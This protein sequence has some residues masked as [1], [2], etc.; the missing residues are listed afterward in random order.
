M[1]IR[2]EGKIYHQRYE[3]GQ[4][5]TELAMTGKTKRRG[6]KVTFKP[7]PEIFPE[8]IFSYDL[9]PSA[10]GSWPSSTGACASTSRTSSP[11]GKTSFTIKGGS[12]PS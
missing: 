12:S 1:E 8:T 5:A 2:R 4:T 9:L 7:D 6:T 11:A 10:C 3:R